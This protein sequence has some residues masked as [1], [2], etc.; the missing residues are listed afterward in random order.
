MG[1]AVICT[2]HQPSAELF[3]MFDALLLLQVSVVLGS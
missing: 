1:K 2:V 3:A